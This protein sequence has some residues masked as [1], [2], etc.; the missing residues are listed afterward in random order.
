MDYINYF[1]EYIS[2]FFFEPTVNYLKLNDFIFQEKIDDKQVD[3]LVN[4]VMTEIKVEKQYIKLRKRY[5]VFVDSF[6]EKIEEEN[7]NYNDKNDNDKND[8]DN[9]SGGMVPMLA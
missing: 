1:I 4:Q 5:D 6:V 7:K 9:D 2:S 8:N 3:N